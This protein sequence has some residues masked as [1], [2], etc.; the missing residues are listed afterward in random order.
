MKNESIE[1]DGVK[2]WVN[3]LSILEE[4]IIRCDYYSDEYN[5]GNYSIVID[6]KITYKLNTICKGNAFLI[7]SFL[8]AAMKINLSKYMIK[9]FTTIGVPYY[10]IK[11]SKKIVYNKILPLT[12]EI[13]C[14]KT[15]KEYMIKIKDEMLE[16]YKNC[17]FF[18]ANILQETRGVID[19]MQ[20]TPVSISMKNF[21]EDKYINYITNSSKN[22]IAFLFELVDDKSIKMD[23]VY[24]TNKFLENTINNI[25]KTFVKILDTVLSDS[26][27]KIK[28]I[29]ILDEADKKKI[30]YDFNDTRIE[31]PKDK[32]IQELFEA[33]VEKTPDNIAV[34]FEDKKLTYRELNEKSNSL[35]RVLRNKGVKADSIVGIMV[36]RSLEMIIG[37]M[38][39]LKAG[40]AYLPIDPKYPKDRIEYILK[41]SGTK[42]L[43]SKSDLVESIGFQDAVIDLFKDDIFT[44]DFNNL[45]KINSSSNL[46]YVI[47]TSGTT[48]NPKGAMIEH[49]AL[50]NRLI[51][52][53]NKYPLNEKDT[54]LQKTTYTFDVSVWELLWWSLVGAKVCMLSPND[55]KDPVKIIEA[56]NKHNITTMHFVPS[57]LD[58]F[59]YCLEE[60]KKASSLSS[61]KQVFCSGEA[62]NFKQVSGF[63][64]EFGDSK[65][66]I[67]LYGPTEATI[68]VSYFET[69]S[70]PDV[71]VIPIGKPISNINLYILDSNRK[72]QPIGVSG[73]LYISGDGLARGYLNK[74]ELTSEKFVDN[75]F[76]LGAKMYKTGDLARWLPNGNIEFLGRIDNQVKVRG[77]RIELGEIESKL[78]QHEDVKEATVTVIEDKNEDKYICSYIVS[79]KEIS[80]LNLKDYLKESL[81]EY[82]IP[83]YFVKLDK[84]PITSNGKLDRRSLPKPNL[85]ERL[86]SY[87]AP[88]ND[89]EETLGR[90][91][92]E[93]LG[94]DKIGINDSFFELGGHSLKAMTLISKIHKET[95]KEV[96]LKELFKSPTIKG[97]SKFI[98]SAKENIYSDIEKIEDKDYYKASSAQKRMYI[99]QSF[100]KESIAYNMP[101]I[102][103]IQGSIDKNKIEDTIRKLAERHEAFRTYFETVEDEIVQKIDSNY[104]FKLKERLENKTIEE[105]ENNFVK[106]FDL[107][108]SPLYRAEIVEIQ[109]KVYLLI[110]M[111][112]I[113]S[114]GVSMSIL[115]NEFASL[116]NGEDLEPLKLQYKDFAAWQNNF[117]KSKDMKKQEEYWINM[118]NDD[119]P[120]LNLPYD[121]ERPAIQ[122]FE[123]DS[124]SFEVDKNIAH[125][126]KELTKKTGTTMHMVL[127]SAF[128]IL[129]SKYS[130][131]EDIVIGTPVAG[132]SH[133][134]LQN[135]MGMLTNTL[136][137]R[138]KPEGNK[139]YIDFLNEVKETS[140]KAYDNQSY[141]LETLIEKLDI[142]RDTSRNPLFDVMFN[143]A[144]TVSDSDINL[145]DMSLILYD[146]ENNVAKIDL[147]LTA[148]EQSDEITI[149][150]EYCSELFNENSIERLGRHYLAILQSITTNTEIKLGE[151][152]LLSDEEKNQLLNEFNDTKVEYPIDKTIQ[153]LFEEE[154]KKIPENIAVKFEDKKLTY[155][156]LNEKSNSLARV[157]RSK[158]VKANSIVGIMVDR[159]LE[160]I[161]GMMGILKAGGA[162]LPID[163]SYPKQR[164]EYMLSDSQSKV[165]LTT[166]SLINDIEFNGEIIDLFR[167]Q[168][169][170]YSSENLEKI[171]NVV[172]IA[173]VIYTSGT[174]GNPKGAMLKHSN[175]SNF[176]MSFNGSFN[177]PIGSKDKVLSL[178]NY[179][180]DVSVCEIFV[181]LTSGA[182]LVINDKH[183][184]FNP[185]EI[186]NLIVENEVTFTY[187]PPLLLTN[188]F[189]EVK[190]S[191]EE[192]KL[193]KLLVG[194]E[195]IRGK[196]LNNFYEL[197]KD[198]E[199]ING[200]GP[201]EATIC[202]TFYKVNGNEAN[203]KI[204]PI[205]N[206]VGNTRIYILDNNKLQPIGVLGELCISGNG[207]AR[208]YLNNPQ[209]T[210]E[211]FVDN[212]FEQGTK[213]YKTGD[214]ARWLPD[215]NIE[216]LGRIDNQVKIRGF[217]IELGEIENKLLQ[218]EGVKEAT[219][220]V[221]DYNDDKHIC[222][223]IVSEKEISELNLNSYLKESLPEY[224][225]PSYFVKLDKMPITSNGK[226]DRRLLP[227]PN[228]DEVLTSY[229]APRNALEETLVR[230]WSEVLGIDKIGINDSFFEL[231]G[232]SLKATML[233]SKIHKELNKEVPLKQLFKLPT[234]KGISRYIEST[235]KSIYSSIEKTQ[236]KEY[237]EASSAQKRMYSLQQFDLKSIGYNMPG[238]MVIEGR[239]NVE[240]LEKSFS[241]LIRRHETLRT[242]FETIEDKIVQKVN[243][244][245]N[246]KLERFEVD[247]IEDSN[248]VV[249]NI[250][251]DFVRAFDLSKAPILR[252]GLIELEENKHI[253]MFDMHH[254]ISDGVSMGILTDEFAKL[255]EGNE[256]EELKIQYKDYSEWQN[257]FLKSE[258]MQKQ[259]EYWINR[260]SDEIPVLNMPVDFHRPSMQSFEG[261]SIS[262]EIDGKLTESLRK[263]VKETGGTMYMVLL[264]G[265]NVLLS[266]YSG[267]EDIIVG[268]PIAGRSHAYLEKIIGMFVNTL[269]MR[270]YP[271]GNMIYEDFLKAVKENSLA[272]YEN[273]DYQFEE[274]VDKL[275][276]SRDIS[277]NPLFDVMFTMQNFESY[278]IELKDL[279]FKG[280]EQETGIAKFDLTLFA[281]ELEENIIFNLQYSTKLY[282]RET[283]ERMIAHFVNILKAV[284]ADTKIKLNE[285]EMLTEEEKYKLLNEFNDTYANCPTD[286]TIH[287]LFEEQ[288]ERTP[289]N[290]AVVYEDK[291]LTYRELN[292]RAN[293]LARALRKNGVKAD[294]IVG[295]MVERSLEMIIGIMGIL[296]AGGAYL[297]IDPN[298][299][300]DRIMYMLEDSETKILL[301]VEHLLNKLDFGGEQL[302]I[303]DENIYSDNVDNLGKTNNSKKLA[304]VIYTSGSTGKPKGVMMQIDSVVNLLLDMQKNY[305]LLSDDTYLFKTSF[306]F[307]VSVAELF[308]W[309]L[310]NGR[311]AIL[312]PGAEKDPNRIARII[313][314]HKITH[315]N[316]VPSMLSV[317]VDK[318]EGCS[319]DSIKSLKYV[320]VAGEKLSNELASKFYN[321]K[322]EGK[323][324]NIYGPTETTYTTGY[325]LNENEMTE[326]IPIGRPLSNIKV[327][328][329]D[330]NNKLAP[331]GVSGELC[332]SG[333]SMSRGY[334]NN[335]ELTA[336]K[337]VENPFS[338]DEKMYRTGDLVRWLP[339][340]NIEFLGRIDHQVKIRGFRIELGE[341]ES[342][343][344]TYE[345]VKEAI[346]V[347]KE[348]ETDSKYLCAYIVSENEIKVRDMREHLLEKLP[349]YMVP[350]YFVQLGEMPLT[351]NGKIDRKA[352]PKPDGS[353]ATGTEYEGPRNEVE[354]KL[355]AIWSEALQ[356]DRVGIN[357]NFFELGGHSLKATML[358]SK[359]HKELNK[360]VP[361]KQLFKLPTI[362]GV[363]GYIESTEKSI[364]S[365]I[366]KT[367]EKEYYEASSAQKRMYSLQQFDLKSIGYNMPGVMVIEGR[368]NVEK[369]EKSFSELIRRHETLRTSFET[370]EDKIVQRVN[371]SVNF[372]VDRFKVDFIEDSNKVVENIVKDFVRAFDLN[373]APLLRIG[374][375][376]LEKDKHILMF[377][378]HH[379]ISD[380]VSMVILIDEFAKIY[381]GKELDELRI[382]YRDFAA[383]Q[384]SFLKSEEMQ[385]QKEYWINRF[386]DEIPVLNMPVDFHRPS[387]QSFEGD[388][389]NFELDKKLTESLRKLA[390]ETGTTMYMV[391]LSGVNI[392]LSKYSG[393][394]D[395][396]IGSPIAGRPHADLEK[397]IGIFVN[398]IAMRNH[399]EE[400][401]TYEDFLKRVK[402]NALKA[403]ENQDYQFDELVEKLSIP[404]DISRNPL[405]DVMFTMQNF[406][407][408]QIKLKGLAVKGYNQENKIAKFDLTLSA[409]ELEENI[410]LNFEYSTKLYKKETIERMVEYFIN[411][412]KVV[413]EDT[414]VKLKKIEMLTKEEKHKLL[415][416]FND[417]YADYPREKTIH[418]LFEEQVER[419]PDNIAVVFEDKKLTYRELNEK[420]NRIART[421]REKGVEADTIVGIMVERSLEMIVGIMGILKAGGAYLPIDPNYPEERI[422]YMLV[423]AKVD[424]LVTSNKLMN[425]V[426]YNTNI[427]VDISDEEISTESS[428]NL[429]LNNKANSLAYV[430]YTSGSTGKPKGVM[431]E[432]RG[433]CNLLLSWQNDFEIKKEDK[434]IQ[435][436]SNSFD[437]SVSEIF[438]ALLLGGKLYIVSEETIGNFE[439]MEAFLIENEITMATFPPQY[440]MNL[441]VNKQYSLEKVVTA[442][443][444][445]NSI[446]VNKWS[447]KVKYI[448]AYGPTEATICSSV[449]KDTWQM[450]QMENV[451]IGKPINNTSIYIVDC[452]YRITPLGV[453]GELCVSGEGL[454]RGYLNRTEL[455]AEKF[456]DNPFKV[457]TKMY[458]TGDLAR[459]LPDG[460]IEFLGRIDHQV[461]IRGFR[462]E[463]GEIESNILTYSGVN[464]TIVVD[465]E[466]ETGSKYL[467]AYIVSEN[468]IKVRDM[469]EHLLEKLPAYM[470]PQYFV[471][472]EKMPLTPNGK[473]D[474]KALPAPDGNLSIGVEYEGPRNEVEEKL[475]SIWGEVLGIEQVGINDN[476]FELGGHSL[477]AVSLIS[478]V[479]KELNVEMSL[480]E[481]FKLPTIKM[482]ARYITCI[483]E[484][485]NKFKYNNVV[486]IKKGSEQA[487]NLFLIHDGSGDI[488]QYVQFCNELNT[489]LNCWGI[490]AERLENY[491]PQNIII[492]DI[493]EKYI[494]II[495]DIQPNGEYNIAG[496]SLGGVIAFEIVRQLEKNHEK[497]NNLV[498][499]DSYAPKRTL[500]NRYLSNKFTIATEKKYIKDFVT[501]KQIKEKINKE[502]SIE[503]I[504]PLI[505]KYFEE[506]NMDT[507]EIKKLMPTNIRRMISVYKKIN[508]SELIHHLN[509]SRTLINAEKVYQ[510]I[511]KIKTQIYFFKASE[512]KGL[513]P[514]I[515]NFYCEKAVKYEEVLGTHFT[516][517]GN[518]LI[519][520]FNKL[521]LVE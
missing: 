247:F 467:C 361:L 353:I 153:E 172:D 3:K 145:N 409:S 518:G 253:L 110:D 333:E 63:Y 436:A 364:Y 191:Q 109:E 147:T 67:N 435:F 347:D 309:F 300:E 385:K 381:E 135:I 372:K 236:E 28:D 279:I 439:K 367:Q 489:D 446:I 122:S 182:T 171:N 220:I 194:V 471:Q 244:N 424:I 362:K 386:S 335:S 184:T 143:M 291:K 235:E 252:V 350:Q 502:T 404:R 224:M 512:S 363:S 476:F 378:M 45:E 78:L 23:I 461:K 312:E 155:R 485:E 430:I 484:K 10:N 384:N 453:P 433:I 164:I 16:I 183:K 14:D 492:E 17:E 450:D 308:G 113:I 517:F 233:M 394:E 500:V 429:I 218:H 457:G 401:L 198:I 87:E 15:Y 18:K 305:P 193:N 315:I 332:V 95:N 251:K 390:K 509:I 211:K 276:I 441:D 99:I 360:E 238:V 112:H 271:L 179:V 281:S 215:G 43:L 317:F 258:E 175:L 187:I 97:L 74:P 454:A 299:P 268:S 60:S 369:L 168:F 131:Q 270:N 242:S 289:N 65:K 59:L 478:K 301:T 79:D 102:F 374:L 416:E 326:N 451:L 336:K 260:F 55:E 34:I 296:K 513:N 210:A 8:V 243:K 38:G 53:Q 375:I 282:K 370:I 148:V 36:E 261:D 186:S 58:V 189:E 206:P 212:P 349:D 495:K 56:I 70:N 402:E 71:K 202:S 54:I 158:G 494:Q 410:I 133:A 491:T 519:E 255:Y 140:L 462:I 80:E 68:D 432:H 452:E 248:K 185:L 328:V 150:I 357:D 493:A 205:G 479:N 49:K 62:L 138:N 387:M 201:T 280:C 126:L 419:T 237:Y 139:K 382:Q 437:A 341:I 445:T 107:S 399:L 499:F 199:I 265:L 298:Y 181:A 197:N 426:K 83:S 325:L 163:P 154:V 33:Q 263:I 521:M 7:Y 440:L 104:E 449:F 101:Q 443:S 96:P 444:Q 27:K 204:L 176:I 456:V 277:R 288:V 2:Y 37:I 230:I 19:V 306:T 226:L 380:G 111:H 377:D 192:V 225:I 468:E 337:F 474:R 355:V 86:T 358:M 134:D 423:D 425:Y 105:V 137:L 84:M 267:Q 21:H 395:I 76:E 146:G 475:A 22:Q 32:T 465:R 178:T 170:N 434:I 124:I 274:L 231:G 165:L 98:E 89:L 311:L 330:K 507:D 166:E 515:W 213:M 397:I 346:V 418:E 275:N 13:N 167:N 144:D 257:N 73:E 356:V 61:L 420:A 116:Y 222:S 327:Y 259:K 114:D 141:Q 44:E 209:L 501:D 20:L 303:Q 127:L 407:S 447:N 130:G 297:P 292:E 313:E 516:I 351:P 234:I 403:Y 520:K 286:K 25:S 103:E 269:A 411:I 310:N 510:P 472:L 132:R 219:V 278:E 323:L 188:V 196:T 393:Q 200:Y 245:V 195:A 324:V 72:L 463:P 64:K 177:S 203:E 414:K 302:N 408:K 406:D 329:I 9:K 417:T 240:K 216:F 11:N 487:R 161:I 405:F 511:N 498:L 90:T 490:S 392:L 427:V 422:E 30:L 503:N 81:P 459:W 88:R 290:I 458:K 421:L 284:T 157:L 481:I 121:Y 496:W 273:Q 486:L 123:G 466:D 373:K 464:E 497:M 66:L 319:T 391:L 57:M 239:L 470:V 455:T 26:N 438:M 477:K 229:E 334:L 398:T 174:T 119:I 128:N 250:V 149:N 254:I 342:N 473:I 48:G 1:F 368:L 39:I 125:E 118:F 506:N 24:N 483:E 47:Y 344:L 389:I 314:K 136:A 12:S 4:E 249:E 241:E 371:E 51:W 160:M 431:I 108:K 246:F 442:G 343:L 82:M 77:F 180:F 217:R 35:A 379:I 338:K 345:G 307:D 52:M 6:E 115:I 227:K 41:D 262:F 400:S 129:L 117:L 318:L 285:I 388:S 91:W 504:W 50:V 69:T 396:I 383:W 221:T 348:D 156:E 46:A 75:P 29:E 304:Y 514:E 106:P 93:V 85:D 480:G 293:S 505:V 508:I 469:R 190:K 294:S 316:F 266:K 482:F 365:L 207:L 352:L 322:I 287:E 151:I 354:E 415:Y 120:V 331:I 142:V 228:L 366:E 295:I 321:S 5:K 94:I 92:S 283:I 376:E 40:G 162:Y 320:F 488:G 413:T 460:N 208:G 169:L 359:I 272:A 340:G 256:L 31:Y 173:Y 428:E 223:Y 264:S 232:H 339:D 100:N 448:N 214:L 152:E 42:M 159:S 412:L